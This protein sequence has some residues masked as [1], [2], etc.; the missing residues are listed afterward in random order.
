[1]IWQKV[2]TL[3]LLFTVRQLIDGSFGP[4]PRGC[5]VSETIS[6]QLVVERGEGTLI[7]FAQGTLGR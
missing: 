4:Q 3:L 5:D 6:K 1:M 7:T 2:T